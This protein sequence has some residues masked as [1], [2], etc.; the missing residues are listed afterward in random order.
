MA[1]AILDA[2]G[3][4]LA[5]WT[6]GSPA[7][8]AASIWQTELAGNADEAELRLLALS[9]QYLAVSVSARP[10]SGLRILPDIPPL[11]LPSVPEA[12][13]PSVRR[14]LAA[15]KETR[16][17]AEFL[18]FLAG[19]GWTAHPADWMPRTGTEE[20]PDVYVPWLDWA[21]I[22]AS[23]DGA[24][25]RPSEGPIAA[26]TWHDYRPAARQLALAELRRRDPAAARLVLEARLVHENADARLRLLQLLPT[27]LSEADVPFLEG[28]VAADRAPKVKAFASA[29][30][31][32]LSRGAA[33]AEDV[34]ELKG[35]FSVQ[36]KGLLRRTRVIRFEN[37][38]TPAQRQRRAELFEVVDVAAVA[39]ALRLSPQDLLAA[40]PWNE[41][42][43][44]DGGLLGLVERTGADA[45][46]VQAADALSQGDASG[47]HGLATLAPRLTPDQR[48]QLAAH[49]LYAHSC[50]FGMARSIA[51]GTARLEDPLAAPAGKPLL[52][53]LRSD[54]KEP[55]DHLAELQ[56][57]GL[58]ASR[59]GARRALER[60][61][62][63]G[64]VQ[65]DPRLEVLRLNAA[66]DDKGAKR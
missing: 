58:V 59:D 46:V 14:V 27:G 43:Q 36:V 39:A 48:S 65:G 34:V 35:Y 55:S 24:S 8:P 1:E 17:R 6:M 25:R 53:A 4:T 22:A 49:I 62:A 18:A 15:I 23:A 11:A 12:L 19:R 28:I 13:R 64:L 10:P 33:A 30:L 63:A 61:T 31:A 7:A 60:L 66:L 26:E 38:K 41:D 52:A 29:L 2:M 56:A 51:G 40:W 5:R 37:A 16:G 32:R 47:L 45:L 20:A 57:L 3:E 54:D 21:E 42:R 50:S 44:A 9:G